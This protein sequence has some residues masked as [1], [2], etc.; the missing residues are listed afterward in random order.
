MIPELVGRLPVSISVDPLDFDALRAILTEPR[1]ALVR[2]YER[3]L[4]LDDVNLSFTPQALDAAAE[5]AMARETGA[6]GLRAIIEGTLLDVMYE[7]PSRPEIREVRVDGDAIRGAGR[8][9]L[10]DAKGQDLP[11]WDEKLPD[12]A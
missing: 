1:N 11:Y 12:A 2:Q 3:L 8:P 7:I 5:L 6:R 9:K 10:M 4:E